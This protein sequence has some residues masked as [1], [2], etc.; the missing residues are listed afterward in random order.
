MR[1]ELLRLPFLAFG[2]SYELVGLMPRDHESKSVSR[3]LRPR[4]AC[5]SVLAPIASVPERMVRDVSER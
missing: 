5:D 1:R 2:R 3:R 4:A